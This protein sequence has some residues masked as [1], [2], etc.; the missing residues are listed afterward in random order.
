[1]WENTDQKKLGIW[2]LHAVSLFG[3][4]EYF[5]ASYFIR[6]TV[7]I[8]RSLQYNAFVKAGSYVLVT[9]LKNIGFYVPFS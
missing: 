4:Q 2:T 7:I 3:M 9:T 1:M 8:L 6:E 5:L